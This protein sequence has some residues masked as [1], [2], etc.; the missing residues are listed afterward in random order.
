MNRATFGR[1]PGGERLKKILAS[2]NYKNN[3]FQNL[4]MTEVLAPGTS[5]FSMIKDYYNKP[6]SVTPPKAL[7]GIKT[8][9]LKIS[10]DKPSVVWF[11]HSSAL[12]KYKNTNILIDPVFSGYAAPVSFLV[13]SF[14]GTDLYTVADLPQIDLVIISHDHYDHLDYETIRQLNAK[15]NKFCVPLGVG[16]HLEHWGIPPEKIIELDWWQ[17]E[18][19]SENLKI[20]STPARHFSGRGFKRGLTLWSSYALEIHGLKVFIG[21]DSGYDTFYKKIGEKFNGFDLV[22]LEAGQYNKKWPLIHMMPEET[23]QAAKDLRA[24]VLLPIHWGKFVLAL[25]PWNEPVKRV[26]ASAKKLKQNV[27]TPVVGEVVHIGGIYPTKQWWN[28]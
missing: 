27:T 12:V 11:G 3:S 5:N 4:T 15:T 28:F 21:G 20:T 8:D 14:P 7:P 26:T 2:P 1:N 16:E 9:L 25:H 18:K 24:K 19:L 6:D 17:S 23:V 13:N 10:A 22:M